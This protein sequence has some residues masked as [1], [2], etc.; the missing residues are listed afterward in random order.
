MILA[1]FGLRNVFSSYLTVLFSRE[2][3]GLIITVG[4]VH[5]TG[6]STPLVTG[7]DKFPGV[8]KRIQS[9]RGYRGWEAAGDTVGP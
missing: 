3:G 6:Y 1:I 9:G 8:S 7:P 4:N 5:Q 2:N